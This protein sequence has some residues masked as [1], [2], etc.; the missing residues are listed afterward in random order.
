M[1]WNVEIVLHLPIFD[2]A[3][4][5]NTQSSKQKERYNKWSHQSWDANGCQC[6]VTST[7]VVRDWSNCKNLVKKKT[8]FKNWSP[9][10]D[11]LCLK[12][13]RA[14]FVP[15]DNLFEIIEFLYAKFLSN[16]IILPLHRLD[17]KK[18]VQKEKFYKICLF[19][20]PQLTFLI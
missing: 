16:A 13:L 8:I 19:F 4:N 18:N 12:F 1:Y 14:K 17:N 15:L 10:W 9:Y 6:H 11:S 7:W 20:G 5:E 2:A 3:T